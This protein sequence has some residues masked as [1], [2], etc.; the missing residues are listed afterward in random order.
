VAHLLFSSAHVTKQSVGPPFSLVCALA[1]HRKQHTRPSS[2]L[3]PFHRAAQLLPPSLFHSLP[4][5]PH[6]SASP[7]TSSSS[8][9]PHPTARRPFLRSLAP[10]LLQ[11]SP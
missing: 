8:P 3:G 7:P 1:A 4:G 11:R 5:R 2:P 6:L 9:A 10:P